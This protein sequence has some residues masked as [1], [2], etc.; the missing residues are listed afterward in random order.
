MFFICS[1]FRLYVLLSS[2]F[3]VLWLPLPTLLGPL[4]DHLG[5]L[6]DHLGPL[7]HHLDPLGAFSGRLGLPSARPLAILTLLYAH[8]GGPL[9]QWTPLGP[10][11]ASFWIDFSLNLNQ[12][13]TIFGAISHIFGDLCGHIFQFSLTSF[14]ALHFFAHIYQHGSAECAERLNTA[15]EPCEHTAVLNRRQSCPIAYLA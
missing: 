12:S 15:G 3:V 14:L 10:P 2:L 1:R 4:A 7:A 9:P 13:L 8:L 6:A 5:P 11:R